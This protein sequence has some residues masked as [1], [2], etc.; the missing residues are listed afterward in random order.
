LKDGTLVQVMP[1]GSTRLMSP[2]ETDWGRLDAM[3]DEE[4]EA[5][6][7]GDPDNP[8]ATQDDLK[9][10]RRGPHP[11][12]LRMSLRLSHEEFSQK[13]SIPLDTLKDWEM[14]RTQPDD[15]ARAY[16]KLIAA[17]PEFV[18]KSIGRTPGTEAAE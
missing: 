5:A 8:P 16:L 1:D 11:R 10:A 18:E 13:F 6:A 17:D 2:S 4:I 9:R 3:T 15:V 14:R 12:F 7:L